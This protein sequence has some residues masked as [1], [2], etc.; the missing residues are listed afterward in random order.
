MINLARRLATRQCT[1]ATARY[2][3][4][5]Y[6]ILELETG[7]TT[8]AIRKAYDELTQNIK[9]EV[10]PE[11]F[12]ALNEAF[13]ILSDLKTRDAYDSLL[14]VRKSF[15]LNDEKPAPLTTRSYLATRKQQRYSNNLT[16]RRV[17]QKE[18]QY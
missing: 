13:V 12:K 3:T 17:S 7:A 4:N 6:D 15:Y 9:P 16:Q 18:D 8:A 1:F 11:R 5:Y 10:D 14:T 2:N